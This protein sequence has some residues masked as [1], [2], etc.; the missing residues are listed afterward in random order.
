ML[1]QLQNAIIYGLLD[2]EPRAYNWVFKLV[3]LEI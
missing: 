3:G 2:A 1:W